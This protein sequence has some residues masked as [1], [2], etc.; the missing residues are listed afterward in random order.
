MEILTRLNAL[1][2]VIVLLLVAGLLSGWMQGLLR[3]LLGMAAFYVALVL[4]AQYHRLLAGWLTGLVPNALP[5]AADSLSFLLIF[6]LGT[7][8]FNWVG[9]HVYAN[10]HLPFLSFL[11]GA[12][13]AIFGFLTSCFQVIIALTVLRFLLGVSWMEWESARQAI[14]AAVKDSALQPIFLASAPAVFALIRPWLPAGLPA[15][16]SF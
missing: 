2:V 11:D 10:T 4:G 9:R 8:L 13:G 15:L 5:V 3:Q 6:G 1:D 16:F 14:S 12:G 7:A